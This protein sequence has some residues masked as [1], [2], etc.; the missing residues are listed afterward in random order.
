MPSTPNLTKS[1]FQN[2]VF[3]GSNDQARLSEF[4]KLIKPVFERALDQVFDEYG[5]G[6]TLKAAKVAGKTLQ[7]ADVGCGEGLYLVDVANRLKKDN[8]LNTAELYGFDLNPVM[9]STAHDLSKQ[10]GLPLNFYVHNVQQ[11][12]E[13]SPDLQLMGRSSFD[14][15]FALRFT[16][17]IT[18]PHQVVQHLYES[19]KPGGVIYL[20]DFTMHDSKEDGW[21]CPPYFQ[22]LYEKFSIAIN[23]LNDGV[24]VAPAHADWLKGMGAT[25]IQTKGDILKSGDGSPEGMLLLRIVMLT[26]RNAVP[27][28]I[29]NGLLTQEQVDTAIEAAF[30]EMNPATELQYALLGTIAQKP[31]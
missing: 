27:M 8:S 26:V 22:L 4:H 30:R 10:L 23:S 18:N 2:Y 14:F 1:N 21:K 12:L 25:N 24:E 19:L 7:V 29:A 28:L 5:L 17:Y 20:L 13:N 9:I 15:I 16:S 11:P 31:A 6:E 3:G